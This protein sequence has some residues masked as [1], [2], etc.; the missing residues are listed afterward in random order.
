LLDNLHVGTTT[1][2]LN[3]QRTPGVVTLEVKRQGSEGCT[4]NFSPAVSLRSEVASV[5]LNGHAIQYQVEP[6]ATDQH[7]A[8][9]IPVTQAAST[10]RIRLKND[11]GVSVANVLPA[12]GVASEGLRV[13]SQTWNASRTQLTLSLS[14]LSGKSYDLSVWNPSQIASVKGGRV[15]EVH[16]DQATLNVEF[17]PHDPASYVHQ[18]VVLNFAGSK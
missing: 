17:P 5:E 6:S 7:V 13:L 11:F 8:M 9:R 18:E 14:G 12:L 16:Q 2:A 4:L 15:G 10:V 3:Y 1:L